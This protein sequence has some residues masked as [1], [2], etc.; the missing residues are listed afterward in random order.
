M[1]SSTPTGNY[2]SLGYYPAPADGDLLGGPVITNPMMTLELCG[3][4][5]Q[6]FP[7]LALENGKQIRILCVNV[8]R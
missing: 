1:P 7:Y 4:D 2:D 8:L 6:G 3:T 5:C